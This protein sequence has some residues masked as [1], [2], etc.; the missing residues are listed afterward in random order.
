MR[1]VAAPDK[2]RGTGSAQ[3]VAGAIARAVS[4]LGGS[5]DMVPMADG[6]EGTLDVL[7][8]PNRSTIVTGPLGDP[9]E[10]QWRLEGRNA[11][12][13]MARAS[14]LDLVG[15]RAGNSPLDATTAG[16]GELILTAVEKG[17]RRVIV[18]LGGSATTDG[19]LGA[20]EA[21]GSLARFRGIELLVACDV[22]TIFVEAAEVFAPQKGASLAQVA[23]LSGRLERLA[24]FYAEEH[25]LDV[26]DLPR[27][28]AAGGLAGGLAAVGAQLI[29]GVYLV[30]E[31]VGLDE[32]VVGA[33]LVVTGEG[34]LDST[35]FEGKVV[36]GVANHA[37]AAGVP[38]LVVAGQVAPNVVGH[39]D[40]ISLVEEFGEERA[41]TDTLTCVEEAV[42]SNLGFRWLG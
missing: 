23:M 39:V 4:A 40:C 15:G 12:I 29:D 27:S 42:K 11:V 28:G 19:G 3:Q 6:G 31:E 1:V 2:F 30:A 32:V 14:G 7:G 26:R 18:G 13:E 9:V 38:L 37:D 22:R 17:A 41:T 36:G 10:A 25:G 8:G 5:A 35:S 16:T 24:Q 33:D 34:R 20:L 21:M